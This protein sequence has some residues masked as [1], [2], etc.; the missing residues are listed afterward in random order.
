MDFHEDREERSPRDDSSRNDKSREPNRSEEG[1]EYSS[2]D[3][4]MRTAGVNSKGYL[5]QVPV[6]R[7][8]LQY[9]VLPAHSSRCQMLG[10]AR[11]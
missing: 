7:D 10:R 11:I 5:A 1:L 4:I 8:S 3:D 9:L 2:F 6:E